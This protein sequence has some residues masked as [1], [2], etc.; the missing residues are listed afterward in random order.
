M[1]LRTSVEKLMDIL[2]RI[3]QWL[4]G[5]VMRA[6]GTLS[7]L[8]TASLAIA[9]TSELFNQWHRYQ[10][11]YLTLVRVRA[12]GNSLQRR[13]QPGLQQVWIPELEVMDRCQT[14]HVAL[15]EVSLSDVSQQPFRPH[16][17][18]P[19]LVTKFGCVICHRGQGAATS[20]EEA[21]NS[22]EAW[23]EPLLPA[24]YLE[25]SCGQCHLDA[26]TG[27]PKVNQG[28]TILAA[29]G[30]A[31][32]H[33][34]TQPDGTKVVATDDPPSLAQISE[35]TTREWIYGWIKNPQAYSSTA[36]MPNFQLSDEDA[37]DIS[38]FL[39]AQSTQPAAEE[40]TAQASAP[41][42]SAIDAASLYGE[43]FCA[44]CHAVQTAAGTVVGGTL[45]PELT[46][47][48]TK[49]RPLWLRRWLHNPADY[50]LE[51]RMPHFRLSVPQIEA[52][53]GFLEQKTDPDFLANVHLSQAT[54]GQIAHGQ[55]LVTEYGCASCHEIKGVKK[56]EN[57]A[58]DLSR[59]GSRQLA[60]I[61]F[62]P[63]LEHTLPA[64]ITA[65]ISDPRSFGASL[66]MPVP[67]LTPA[68]VEAATVALLAQT[69]RAYALPAS[70]RVAA[71][72][73]SSYEPAGEAGK[74]IRDLRCFSC[75]QI[76]GRGGDMAPDLTWEGSSVQQRWL[77]SFLKNPN[78]LR[79]ALIRRMPKFNL[80]DSEIKA[81]SNY[82]RTVYQTPEFDQDSGP[83]T[84]DAAAIERGDQL[85]YS[86][87]AC[88]S[89]HIA[90]Y[91]T[92]KG[93][94]GPAL[95]EVGNRLTPAW[96]FHYLKDPQRLRPGT[97]E[98]DQ[99]IS[100]NDARDLTAFLT[101]LK[102]KKSEAR[103]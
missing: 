66:K 46:R 63:G 69:D 102:G 82:I 47:I 88:Q 15:K 4:F 86:K 33:N 78:T 16:P 99:H 85:F 30:C 73:Q 20:V 59:V 74:L 55:K 37:R 23:E 44:S 97:L 42:P 25:A 58:P 80:T 57:F 71:V 100:D 89:C 7:L 28:R 45:G 83:S 103:R 70:L 17:P 62:K 35:K 13:F 43:S 92:D 52:L 48:G 98:P 72:K 2:K 21:H 3:R 36:T 51:T 60:Q 75:H 49:A 61:L 84:I 22:T 81:L 67:N 38:A 76:N 40:K 18:I 24:R 31:R 1:V 14:C 64:Y 90:D 27:T 68:Q 54:P 34:I 32:C 94:I 10:R 91:K 101:T 53:A 8:L 12:D 77:E 29:Y 65:K 39:F 79:P 5:D 6:F 93:Y 19:H 41:S 87:Y 96:I 11:G 95:A 9:P 50:D 26:L 56:P